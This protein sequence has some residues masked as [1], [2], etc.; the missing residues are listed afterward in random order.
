VQNA[1]ATEVTEIAEGGEQFS[2]SSRIGEGDQKIA[3]ANDR[4]WCRLSSN[5]WQRDD[6]IRI[7]ML[8]QQL[9]IL[10][11][12]A[13]QAKVISKALATENETRAKRYAWFAVLSSPV[14][15]IV[16]PVGVWLPPCFC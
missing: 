10:Q 8:A 6:D 7:A 5:R 16:V 9:E 15:G 12:D 2:V 11:D 4:R 1:R 14:V 3:S 13:E